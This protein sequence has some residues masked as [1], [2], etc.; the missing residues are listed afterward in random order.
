LVML[1]MTQSEALN[2]PSLF[3]MSDPSPENT[4]WVVPPVI[5]KVTVPPG[6]TVASAGTHLF[7]AVPSM[8]TWF[9]TDCASAGLPAVRTSP[10]PSRATA[11][12]SGRRRGRLRAT[13]RC[14]GCGALL[15]GS[16]GDEPGPPV[17]SVRPAAGL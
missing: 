11:M 4:G 12:A 8:V 2:L 17:G 16:G 15:S 1:A 14:M 3:S 5:S 6:R 13:A 7:S 10:A 9:G